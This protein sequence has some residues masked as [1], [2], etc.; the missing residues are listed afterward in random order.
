MEHP[1]RLAALAVVV[2]CAKSPPSPAPA[3]PVA[4]TASAAAQIVAP[5]AGARDAR[6]IDFCADA[7]VPVVVRVEREISSECYPADPRQCN[8]VVPMRI[9]NCSKTTLGAIGV[10]QLAQTRDEVERGFKFDD[11]DL[12]PGATKLLPVPVDRDGTIRYEIVVWDEAWQEAMSPIPITV[13]VRDPARERAR[14]LYCVDLADAGTTNAPA[15]PLPPGVVELTMERTPCYG[16]CPHYRVS[17]RNDGTVI[18]EGLHTVRAQGTFVGQVPTD[19]VIDLVMRFEASFSEAGL[20]NPNRHCPVQHDAPKIVLELHRGGK[21]IALPVLG[22]CRPPHERE[23]AHDIDRVAG[24]ERWVT[25]SD[26][27]RARGLW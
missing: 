10:R 13:M 6:A 21:N 18:Y 12:A 22:G 8:R 25:G 19:A 7:G 15:P 20:H 1:G 16:S 23:I 3:P 14:A 9:A 4:T 2:A 5:D 17:L 26:E 27:C 11:D 24:T